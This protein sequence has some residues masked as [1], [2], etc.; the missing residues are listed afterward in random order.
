MVPIGKVLVESREGQGKRGEIASDIQEKDV[1]LITVF[2]EGSQ[3]RKNRGEKC[4]LNL[5][6]RKEPAIGTNL[7]AIREGRSY[8]R[9]KRTFCQKRGS[10]EQVG[11]YREKTSEE[12]LLAVIEG[13]AR[14]WGK[15]VLLAAWEKKRRFLPKAFASAKGG[16]KGH[17]SHPGRRKEIAQGGRGRG[18]DNRSGRAGSLHGRGTVEEEKLLPEKGPIFFSGKERD[19][20]NFA[21]H[22]Q[23]SPGKTA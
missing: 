8:R 2:F 7:I 18:K 10:V 14:M 9:G 22:A 17:F 20:G 12:N 3:Q 13:G 16:E 6:E 11:Y 23:G 15:R 21:D 1:S 5:P 4:S 19:K